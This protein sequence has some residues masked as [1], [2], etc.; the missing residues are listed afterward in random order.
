MALQVIRDATAT[1]PPMYLIDSDPLTYSFDL[2]ENAEIGQILIRTDIPSTYCKTGPA[3]NDWLQTGN[4]GG[5]PV[6]GP[7]S[8]IDFSVS[9]AAADL[10]KANQLVLRTGGTAGSPNVIG[11]F[12]GGGVGNKSIAGKY[13]FGGFNISSLQSIEVTW[14]NLLG[15]GGPFFNPPTPGTVQTPY[16]NF[17]VDFGGGDLRVVLAMADPLNPAISNSIGTYLNPGGLNTMVYKWD[18]TM[19]VCIVGTPPNPVPGGVV[20]IVSVGPTFLDNAYSWAALKAANPTAK[21]VDA[22]PANTVLFPNGDGGL[23]VGAV[24]PSILLISGDSGNL[25]K[26]SKLVTSYKI[27]GVQVLA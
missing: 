14:N 13:G 23:P 18:D 15:L 2:D 1:R 21:F 22:F 10:F 5:I 20:P 11:A 16:L 6:V 12:N 9:R 26:S 17:I 4:S 27:N 24:L 7:G 25:S 3:P 8:I 19:N